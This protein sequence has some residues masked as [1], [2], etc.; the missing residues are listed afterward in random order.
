MFL[1]SMNKEG[2]VLDYLGRTLPSKIEDN[3]EEVLSLLDRALS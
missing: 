2:E 3:V 1:K